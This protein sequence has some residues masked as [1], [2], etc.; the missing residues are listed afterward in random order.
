MEVAQKLDFDSCDYDSEEFNVSFHT[1]SSGCDV[2]EPLDTS[3][4]DFG[5]SPSDCVG[6]TSPRRGK[7]SL[8]ARDW[9][10]TLNSVCEDD[11]PE[12]DMACASSPYRS[13]DEKKCDVGSPPYKR[14]RALRLFDTPATPKTILEKCNALH[15][16]TPAPRSRFFRPVE[17]RGT[18]NL[19]A[20]KPAAN[21]NPFTPSGM[22][23]VS[24]KRTRSKRSLDG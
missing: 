19:T 24:K 13:S 11:E 14:V 20:D 7:F 10:Q 8:R 23:L 5:S 4:E 21:L 1:I 12:S 6:T 9:N 2:G 22:L 15:L 3:N 18:P 16:Q 17:K